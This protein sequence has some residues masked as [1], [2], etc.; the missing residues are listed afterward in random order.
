MSDGVEP[1]LA[2][3]LPPLANS[4]RVASL[5]HLSRISHGLDLDNKPRESW[6]PLDSASGPQEVSCF[7]LSPELL[8]VR[9]CRAA[10]SL[11]TD[12][13][14]VQTESL[15]FTMDPFESPFFRRYDHLTHTRQRT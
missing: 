15:E 13:I 11:E 5:T 1:K 9:R 8:E 3:R 6:S 2:T 14:T 4:D 7:C 12:K 10:T